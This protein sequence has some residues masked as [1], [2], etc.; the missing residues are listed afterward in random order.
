[1]KLD[2]LVN[3]FVRFK[4]HE[5]TKTYEATILAIDSSGY[6]VQG[7]SLCEYLCGSAENASFLEYTRAS[8][9]FSGSRL[10]ERISHCC[11][12]IPLPLT[13]LAWEIDDQ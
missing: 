11:R 5:S 13:I 7:G 4:L 2:P 8:T 3:Q 1:M 10:C 6:W 12:E 9:G